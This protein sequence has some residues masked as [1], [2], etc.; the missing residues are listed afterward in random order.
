MISKIKLI[1]AGTY[2]EFLDYLNKNKISKFDRNIRYVSDLKQ[3]LG[4]EPGNVEIIYHGRYWLNPLMNDDKSVALLNYLNFS[5]NIL[6]ENK[7][8]AKRNIKK[9]IDKEVDKCIES[10]IKDVHYEHTYPAHTAYYQLDIEKFRK[11]LRKSFLK[12]VKNI[13]R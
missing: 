4:Y 5:K 3:I 13:R 11:K 7:G 1:V 2:S 8:F 10:L 12:I 6:K 9:I